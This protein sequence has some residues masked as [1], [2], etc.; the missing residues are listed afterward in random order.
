MCSRQ[1]RPIHRSRLFLRRCSAV[2]E[3]LPQLPG[4][5]PADEH[6]DSDDDLVDEASTVR[7]QERMVGIVTR[8]NADRGYGFI[9]VEGRPDVYFHVSE[10]ERARRRGDLPANS[11]DGKAVSFRIAPDRRDQTKCK[12]IELRLAKENNE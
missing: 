4:Q 11:L 9:R 2:A 3:L 6:H 10:V 8:F 5:Q 1:L 12:A 7:D